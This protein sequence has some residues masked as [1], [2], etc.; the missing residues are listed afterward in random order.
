LI[1]PVDSWLAH[2]A[3]ILCQNRMSF[4]DAKVYIDYRLA[5]VQPP[6]AV[7]LALH[8]ETVERAWQENQQAFRAL[9]DV[10]R[11]I[12]RTAEALGKVLFALEKENLP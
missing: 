2:A 12:L 1:P 8:E 9:A 7:P 4:A 5:V 11:A 3:C 10:E 6:Y